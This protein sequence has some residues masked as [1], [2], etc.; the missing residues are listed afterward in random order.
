MRKVA[1]LALPLGLAL[2]STA[3]AQ[4]KPPEPPPTEAPK[5][6]ADAVSA[7]LPPD[8]QAEF[9]G[10]RIL[11]RNKDYAGALI[12]FRRAKELGKS[13]AVLWSVAACLKN[14]ADYAG[15]IE[16]L[17][18]LAAAPRAEALSLGV[19]EDELNQIPGLLAT[20]MRFVGPLRLHVSHAGADV[21]IDNK[22]LAG[23]T[24]IPQRLLLNLGNRKV[25]VEKQGFKS[26]EMTVQIAGGGAEAKLTIGLEPI[27]HE[28]R[29]VVNVGAD[30]LV[31]LDGKMVSRGRWE[32]NIPSGGHALKVTAPGK[33]PKE[34]E[35]TVTDGQRRELHVTLMKEPASPAKWI[36]LGVGGAVLTGAVIAGGVLAGSSS[37]VPIRG[38]LPPISFLN[39][40]HQ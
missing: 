7:R 30:E 18:A 2:S 37:G 40:G 8:A 5:S 15:F 25:R 14:L 38:T 23:K 35:V 9:E 22:P 36:W 34:Q 27:V 13:V 3:W 24:P 11:F 12:K 17:N 29:L 39:R 33:L 16:A 26:V 10:G 1:F 6:G 32:G 28:G 19:A 21:L 20:A 4:K 31:W